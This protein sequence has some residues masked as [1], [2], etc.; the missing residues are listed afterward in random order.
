MDWSPTPRAVPERAHKVNARID[1]IEFLIIDSERSG[2]FLKGP[3]PRVYV[4]F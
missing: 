2:A 1:V 3:A 4:D